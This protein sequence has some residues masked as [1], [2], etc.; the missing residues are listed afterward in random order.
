MTVDRWVDLTVERL[1]YWRADSSVAEKADSKDCCLA[2]LK[3]VT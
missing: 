3:D 1:V 2:A